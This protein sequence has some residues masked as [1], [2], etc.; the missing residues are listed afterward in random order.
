MSEYNIEKID[1]DQWLRDVFPEW[2]TWLNEEIEETKVPEGKF[3]MWWLACTGIWV[4]TPGDANFTVDFWVGRGLSTH[5]L[6]PYEE[7]K[8]FQKTVR[9]IK[10]TKP[11]IVNIS[12][13]GPRPG[14]KAAEMRQLTRE[15]I[16]D[17]TKKLVELVEDIKLSNNQKWLDWEGEVLID[18]MGKKGGLIGR[19]FAY[20][21][22]LTKGKIGNF[23]EVKIKSVRPT[24]L[25]AE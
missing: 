24:Y 5:K 22:V 19:N 18:E 3:I 16:N 20:K 2:G 17:R 1:R 14:T 9:L 6:P 11:D 7:R 15:I 13:F 25:I 12:K 10:E 8:D 21:P 4:K 23:K